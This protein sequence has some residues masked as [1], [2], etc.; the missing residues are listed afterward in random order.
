MKVCFCNLQ[1]K[2]KIDDTKHTGLLCPFLGVSYMTPASISFVLNLAEYG[3]QK[4]ESV[5]VGDTN[6][7]A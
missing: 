5:N 7:E 1:L 4:Y 6:G 3:M 2:I